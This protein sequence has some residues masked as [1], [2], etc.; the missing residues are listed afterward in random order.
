[1]VASR[2]SVLILGLA[3]ALNAHGIPK[4]IQTIREMYQQAPELWEKPNTYP[5]IA[6]KEL[7]PLPKQAPFPADNPYSKPKAEL[8]ER[9][10]YDP[11]LSL[12]QKI[13][14]AHCHKKD[15]AFGDNTPLSKGHLNQKGS[16]NAPSILMSAF[17]REK[18]W[19]SRAKSLEDQALE[20]I[21]DHQEMAL[22]LQDLLAYLNSS[23]TYQKAFYKAFKQSPI[24]QEQVAMALA[25]YERTLMPKRGAFDRFLLGEKN[26]LSNQEVWG[27]HLF[28]TK[29]GCMNC[30][31]G[32]AF[33]DGKTHNL[34]LSYYGRKYQDLGKGAW[35]QDPKDLG[36][37]KTPSLRGVSRSAPYMHNGLFPSLRGILNAYNAGM[38]HPLPPPHMPPPYPQ[39]SPLLK[40]LFL[41]PEELDAIESFLKTL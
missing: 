18:F 12:S 38:F 6:Y 31:Y 19:D 28:R 5:N 2:L 41:T 24:T 14:C 20:P 16:R 22:P 37:F 27:L 13:S 7:A 39:T 8:G 15:F 34:G 32:I 29:A 9:L 30:H 35:S 10:F 40:P 26:A 17:G 1:M 4:D 11:K 25:T 21:Q 3:L 36:A 33:S 23:P